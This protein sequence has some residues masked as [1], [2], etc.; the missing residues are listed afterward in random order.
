[1]EESESLH[2]ESKKGEE[3]MEKA[4]QLANK[5]LRDR[6][7]KEDE[8]N[9]KVLDEII[10]TDI[11]CVTGTYDHI[12]LVLKHLSLPFTSIN[13]DQLLSTKL[14]SSQTVFVN[15]ASSFPEEGARQLATFVSKGGQLI[16]TDWAVKNV[17]QIGFPGFVE[18]NGTTTH[19]EVIKDRSN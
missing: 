3:K 2:E 9:I 19:D 15:C 12:H 10:R 7:K 11:I 18:H 14:K 4:Y 8:K 6:L 17:L 16:T 5:L 1:M 13:H